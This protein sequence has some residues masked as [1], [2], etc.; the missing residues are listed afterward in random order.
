[1]LSIISPS[2]ERILVFFLIILA[3]NFPF[4]GTYHTELGYT[5]CGEDRHLKNCQTYYERSLHLNPIF[6]FPYITIQG[7]GLLAKSA[8]PSEDAIIPLLEFQKD[9][10]ILALFMTIVFWYLAACIMVSPL[11][12]PKKSDD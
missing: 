4:V 3:S 1:M 12:Q 11:S 9:P 5:A 8:S 2:K 6:W 7:N 10:Q